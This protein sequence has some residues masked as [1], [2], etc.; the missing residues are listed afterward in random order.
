[1]AN[2]PS[3]TPSS[4]K[5]LFRFIIVTVLAL[6]VLAGITVL[7]V[8]LVIR[9]KQL[10]YTIEDGSVH[11][12][13]MKYNHVNASFNFLMKVQNP[14]RK[15]SVFYDSMQVTVLYD[16]E[17]IAFDIVEP[18]FLSHH[19]VTHLM[20]KPVARSAPL[21]ASTARGLSAERSFGEM[22]LTIKMKAKIRYKVG[23]WKSSKRNLW[24]TC[25]SV[26]LLFS[27]S[28]SFERIKCDTNS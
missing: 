28:K 27:S 3:S 17:P 7:I 23:K 14:S 24:T 11:G 10:V 12:Y 8:W 9:P 15:V 22:E 21:L 19:N 20:L 26:G 16:D 2:P 6:I 1:M 4:R 5:N 13:D 25:S 18:F